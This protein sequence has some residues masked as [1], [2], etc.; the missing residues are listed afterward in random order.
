M[1]P[2]RPDIAA[3]EVPP[4]VEWVGEGPSSMTRLTAAGP[5]LVHFFDFAQL[6]SVRSLPYVR[7]WQRR[8]REAGLAVLGV[9]APRYAFGADP[10]VVA[11][12]LEALEIS[13]P[14]A[15]DRD[16]RLW[17]DYG[18]QGWPSL[19][20]WAR[21]GVLRWYHLGE[22]EY[23]ATE[24]AIQ[25]QLREGDA[26]RELPPPMRPL[27][28]TD[29]PGAAV[30]PPSAEVFPGGKKEPLRLSADA[31]PLEL[32]YEAGGAF[33]TV[34]GRGELAIMVDGEPAAHLRVGGAGLYELAAHP[35]HEAH[36]LELGVASGEVA[37][38]SISFAP[39][40]P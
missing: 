35:R 2:G 28:P 3:P 32:G 39:G 20:L 22:G 14:V 16:H 19:F 13:H 37:I 8:Y 34:E 40:V 25:E 33:A 30:M 36:L 7:E 24:D 17:R 11:R 5:A 23:A 26:L 31:E 10:E 27:R 29:A 4:D 15:I 9:Q 6:N 21:G 38:W 18:C 1:R 12:G